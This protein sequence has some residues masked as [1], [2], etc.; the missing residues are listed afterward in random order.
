MIDQLICDTTGK[1]LNV[2]RAE[3]SISYSF[4]TK[5]PKI[6]FDNDVKM[7]LK[8]HPALFLKLGGTPSLKNETIFQGKNIRDIFKYN[9]NINAGIAICTF[10]QM[11]LNTT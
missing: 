10:I 4:V 9:P 5:P 6:R 1:A 7:G 3:F 8:L 11:L 2:R